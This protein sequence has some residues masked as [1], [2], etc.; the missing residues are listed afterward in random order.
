MRYL[1]RNNTYVPQEEKILFREVLDISNYEKH[2]SRWE[3][4]NHS[5]EKISSH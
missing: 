3:D 1:R 2:I 4:N 5:R